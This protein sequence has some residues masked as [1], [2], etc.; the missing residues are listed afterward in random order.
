M[1]EMKEQAMPITMTEAEK[2]RDALARRMHDAII[3][4][5]IRED[6]DRVV[7]ELF[8]GMDQRMVLG[9]IADLTESLIVDV[10]NAGNDYGCDWARMV[11][12]VHGEM[13]RWV[14]GLSEE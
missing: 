5:L 10:A 3:C 13:L 12:E 2:D 7:E 11:N 1:S 6:D 14:T 9:A 4:E 8:K